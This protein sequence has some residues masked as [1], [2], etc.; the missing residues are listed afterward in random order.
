VGGY[1]LTAAGGSFGESVLEADDPIPNPDRSPGF[2][3]GP[4]WAQGNNGSLYSPGA[5]SGGRRLQ[6]EAFDAFNLEDRSWTFEGWL[7]HEDTLP[8]AG[9]FGDII[10]GTRDGNIGYG[11]GSFGGFSLRLTN[12][13]LLSA[14]FDDRSVPFSV[15]SP[16]A[17]ALGPET[18]HHFA[19]TW[20]DGAGTNGTGLAELFLNGG[21][22]GSASAPLGFSAAA[23]DAN[24]SNGFLIAGRLGAG[25]NNWD[26]RLDELRFV[27]GVL[28][29]GTFLNAPEPGALAIWALGLTLAAAV[30]TR[31]RNRRRP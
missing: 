14:Y 11:G 13:G 22:V 23:A 28:G 5:D 30:A 18:W 7:Q 8:A 10:G 15:S 24:D 19:L 20:E 12:T 3:G 31:R 25:N 26:G 16:T 9:S 2:D 1:D 27:R 29:P 4:A 21:L 6:T 17:V